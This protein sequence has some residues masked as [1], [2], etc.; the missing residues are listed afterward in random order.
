[1]PGLVS[2][3]DL[4]PVITD[5][6]QIEYRGRHPL[7]Y[8]ELEQPETKKLSSYLEQ[9]GYGAATN[10]VVRMAFDKAAIGKYQ[11]A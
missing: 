4:I 1:M 9:K 3:E 2:V 5:F 11:L 7:T 6:L 8:G 10:A